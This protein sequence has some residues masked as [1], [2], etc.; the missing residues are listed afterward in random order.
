M[1]LNGILEAFHASSASPAQIAKQARWMIASSGAF[2]AGLWVLSGTRPGGISTEQCLVYASCISMIVRI[3]YAGS[4][5]GRFLFSDK[6][7][8]RITE[9]LPHP[10]ILAIAAVG[11]AVLRSLEG[12]KILAGVGVF[13]LIVLAAL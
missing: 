4:H 5:A 7:P 12:I 3:V 8:I 13:G 11:A 1:S 2:A 6:L 10:T 9:I